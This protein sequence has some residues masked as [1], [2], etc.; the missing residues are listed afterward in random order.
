[1]GIIHALQVV[2]QPG[3]FR[4]TALLKHTH[5]LRKL[6]MTTTTLNTYYCAFCAAVA[7]F[8]NKFFTKTM[9]AFEAMGRARAAAQ[10]AQMGYHKEAKAIMLGK[11]VEE[12]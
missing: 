4:G 3:K 5:I 12:V 9:S 11:S 8:A 1:L 7:K 10:L 6:K 2:A